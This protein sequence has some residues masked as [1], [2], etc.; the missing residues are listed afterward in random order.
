MFKKLLTAITLSAIATVAYANSAQAAGFKSIR[1]GDRDGFGYGTG[2]GYQGAY[3]GNANVD[4][5]GVLGVNDLLPDLNKDNRLAINSGDDFDNRSMIEKGSNYITGS[6]FTDN[7]SSGS[8]FTD[9]SLSTSLIK[10]NN[11]ED[12]GFTQADVSNSK[13]PLPNLDFNFS[14]GGNDIKQGTDMYFNMLFGDYDVKDAKVEFTRADGSKFTSQLTK[15]QNNQ[16]QDG[17][18]QSAFVKLNFGDIFTSTNN[19]YNGSLQAK[20]IAK[21]EPYL[22]F[23]FAELSTNQIS[24]DAQDVPEPS[25]ALGILALSGGMFLRKGK[26]RKSVQ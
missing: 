1:I 2:Q 16:G 10:T 22:T 4:G 13:I 23:D 9:I 3:G 20:I 6:G 24:L 26:Q 8:Q 7:G 5:K 25:I 14:V 19:G 11:L 18:I 17:L 21:D 12:K 15:Q